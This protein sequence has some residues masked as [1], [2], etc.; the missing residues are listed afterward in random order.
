MKNRRLPTY[1]SPE[2]QA[3]YAEAVPVSHNV[4]V[5]DPK[6]VAAFRNETH[7]HWASTLEAIDYPFYLQEEYVSGVRCVRI[8]TE[9]TLKT[10]RL[11][12]L[13][14][15]GAYVLGTPEANASSAI[16]LAEATGLPVLSVDYRLAPEHP[17]P[18][19]LNDAITAFKALAREKYNAKNMILLGE[20]AGAGLALSLCLTL[21]DDGHPLPGGLVLI[22]PW[23]D[24][25]QHGDSLT[26]LI[27]ADLDFANPEALYDCATA[28]APLASLSDPLI[29]PVN[30]SLHHL[31]PMLIH[32]GAREMLLSDSLRLA[33]NAREANTPV[34]LDVWDGMGHLFHA[35][36]N[37][38]E[39]GKAY[40]RIDRFIKERL[41][42]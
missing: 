39:A 2:A 27:D 8:T 15:G 21:R 35:F 32:V 23:A 11:I 37:L 36:P 31:P 42:Q 22:S 13:L 1:I 40:R 26:T 17:F 38:P 16:A 41:C 33:S 9:R 6:A 14:H 20:S 34:E 19:G 3:Y 12:V 5:T 25:E 18:A 28:Y 10:D 7:A 24:L 4:D 29:S 30:A